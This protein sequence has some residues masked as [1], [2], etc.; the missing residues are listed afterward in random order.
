MTSTPKAAHTAM[1]S[2][3]LDYHIHLN[4]SPCRDGHTKL[5]VHSKH[6]EGS[7]LRPHIIYIANSERLLLCMYSTV[8]TKAYSCL[9]VLF[10]LRLWAAVA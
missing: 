10:V 3:S 6:A 5:T 1:H 9:V 8:I 7:L 4:H 2:F